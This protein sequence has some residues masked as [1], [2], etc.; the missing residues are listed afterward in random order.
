MNIRLNWYHGCSESD[1]EKICNEGILF[2]ER[3]TPSRC[4]YLACQKEDAEKYGD[5]LLKVFYDPSINPEM[6]NY[7][8]DIDIWQIRVYEPILI[9]NVEKL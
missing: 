5:I 9:C 7:Y 6:N 3:G 1:W 4:T 8:P 2:G